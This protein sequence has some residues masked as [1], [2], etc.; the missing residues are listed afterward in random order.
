MFVH[1][2]IE[3]MEREYNPLA[4]LRQ[5]NLSERTKDKIL[6]ISIAVFGAIGSYFLL[7][8]YIELRTKDLNRTPAVVFQEGAH[9]PAA[10]PFAE[11]IDASMGSQLLI[12][13]EAVVNHPLKVSFINYRPD[14]MF[15]L[16]FGNGVRKQ[17]TSTHMIIQYN[18]AG[19][20]IVQC[21][22]KDNTKSWRR[23]ATQTLTIQN[24]SQDLSEL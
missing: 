10:R 17:M 18:Q 8:K 12:E 24:N 11:G 20:Y 19:I 7:D 23:I 14:E 5:H 3:S 13:G 16:D 6:S 22:K 4:L 2:I 21:F 9:T 15:L 1:P